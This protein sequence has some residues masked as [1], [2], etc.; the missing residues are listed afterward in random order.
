MK[1]DF[2]NAFLGLSLAQA[3]FLTEETDEV[4]SSVHERRIPVPLAVAS[5]SASRL[6]LWDAALMISQLVAPRATPISTTYTQNC[7]AVHVE[8]F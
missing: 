4:Y 5:A 2:Q 8:Q 3:S 1:L 7:R 6:G